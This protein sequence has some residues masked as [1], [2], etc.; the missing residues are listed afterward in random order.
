[1]KPFVVTV[2]I[3]VPPCETGAEAIDLVDEILEEF[4]D[5]TWDIKS[6]GPAVYEVKG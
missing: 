3:H 1:M 5:I 2:E 4:E 6:V